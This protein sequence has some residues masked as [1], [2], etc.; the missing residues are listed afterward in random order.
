MFL[1]VAH[2]RAEGVSAVMY[3]TEWFTTM[4]VYSLPRETCAAVW[5]CFFFGGGPLALFRCSVALLRL[6]EPDLLGL[7]MED[8]V[9]F[10]KK[11]TKHVS[12]EAL[13]RMQ[14]QVYLTRATE[15]LL[16]ER[17]S[18]KWIEDRGIRTLTCM[19]QEENILR[20][21]SH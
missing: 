1:L 2:F 16:Q 18:V 6:L 5:D 15:R 3:V 8:I 7:P 13:M 20:R 12:V 17:L 10:L 19:V 9:I 14:R 4:F 21:D 11:R